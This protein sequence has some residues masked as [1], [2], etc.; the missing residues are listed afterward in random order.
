ML[1]KVLPVAAL[2]GAAMAACP[3]SVEIAG[4]TDHTLH[5][6]VTNTGDEAVTVFKGNTV[7][8]EHNTMDIMVADEGM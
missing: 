3:L 1:S 6:S 4:S 2:A 7:L 5:V 8:S